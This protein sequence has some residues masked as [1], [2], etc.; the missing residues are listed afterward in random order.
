LVETNPK[1]LSAEKKR[2][3]MFDIPTISVL[4]SHSILAILPISIALITILL[5]LIGIEGWGARKF[6]HIV[7][8]TIAGIYMVLIYNFWIVLFVILI[9]LFVVLLLSLPPIRLLPRITELTTRTNESKLIMIINIASTSFGGLLFFVVLGLLGW[10][11]PFVILCG[12]WALANGDGMGEVIGKPFGRHKYKIFSQKSVE[13]SIGVF[14]G[15]FISF[16]I[17]SV[18]V[19]TLSL[20]IF[21]IILILS[22]IT[23]II[24]AISWA[25]IDNLVIPPIIGFLC[26]ILVFQIF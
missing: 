21:I 11:H 16:L 2:K 15:S 8:N 1:F 19:Y 9:G 20:Q 17:A 4:L 13:G 6:G 25:F 14:F 26:Y 10:A 24:E 5:P 12:I 23:V 7:G 3:V 22:I 18:W